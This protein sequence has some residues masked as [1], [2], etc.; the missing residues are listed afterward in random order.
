MKTFLQAAAT[1]ALILLITCASVF[2]Q[3]TSNDSEPI[4]EYRAFRAS[5]VPG[6]STNGVEASQYSAKY[7]LNIIA[8]YNGGLDDGYELGLININ[9]YYTYARFQAGLVNVTGGRHSGINLAAIGNFS[10]G[11]MQGIQLSGIGNASD[12]YM[13]G[14]QFSGV[15][16]VTSS[17]MQG[18]QYGGFVN[19]AAGGMQGVQLAGV[20]N[21]AGGN[22]QGVQLAGVINV[23]SGNAEGL[24]FS[25]V[26]NVSSGST[27]GIFGSGVLNVSGGSSQGMYLAG[28]G[29]ASGGS[30]QGV[31]LA[32]VG[33]IS[34]GSTQGMYLAG[35]GNLSSGSS[36]GVYLAGIGNLT[37]GSSQG[38][39]LAGIGNISSG[40][41]Q[42]IFL[43]GILNNSTTLQGIAVSGM[44]NV[45]QDF[46][47]I[48]VG[49]LANISYSGQGIQVAPFNY[50]RTFEGV[51]VG[52][53][54]WYGDGRK[55]IDVWAN[56]LGFVNVGLK[57]GTH[58]IHNMISLGYNTTITDRE[59]WA[60]TW[61]VGDNR[62]LQEAW[63]RPESSSYF[64]KR[65]FSVQ[66]IFDEEWF[67]SE[68]NRVYSYR[69]LIGNQI[70]NDFGV[71][72]GP[73]VNVLV[74]DVDGATDYPLYSIFETGRSG[75]EFRFWIG[76]NIGIQLF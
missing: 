13:Q 26:T 21:A 70:S 65:D 66:H 68:M 48:Q 47:G 59:V 30:S 67:G 64:V 27:Q 9:R 35:I 44:L 71:Y 4:L 42:G 22:T 29:N 11:P 60:F 18:I 51:P 1:L 17:D 43:S 45:T 38:M 6:L 2:A 28:I 8:G 16:N 61:N 55:N 33:N 37:S 49:G 5:F 15:F 54:S 39:Y 31:Y 73:T 74:T 40:S 75:T 20:V 14:V 46:Q 12:G 25:G 36:Q 34:G 7:S 52:L 41:S 32:G 76:F 24:Q 58:R 62:S 19:I 10:D 72:G 56:D 63:N 23:N 50:A 3:D 57:T 53:I 69:Y